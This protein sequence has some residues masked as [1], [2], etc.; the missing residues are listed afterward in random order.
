MT[1]QEAFA[2]L[3]IRGRVTRAE[4][5]SAYID[6]VTACRPGRFS[7]DP[8][9]QCEAEAQ[10]K[11]VTV[12]YEFLSTKQLNEPSAG[13]ALF[14]TETSLAWVAVRPASAQPPSPEPSAGLALFEEETPLPPATAAPNHHPS[15]ANKRHHAPVTR[16]GEAWQR[17]AQF[18]E[19]LEETGNT[20]SSFIVKS[21]IGTAILMAIPVGAVWFLFVVVGWLLS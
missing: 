10:L 7:N 19:R 4:L 12:A 18:S 11:L 15:A 16:S 8:S 6:S 20:P 1:C 13:L 3:G 5:Q 17:A 9:V 2:I 21:L 14:E